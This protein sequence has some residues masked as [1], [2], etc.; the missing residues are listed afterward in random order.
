MKLRLMTGL[1]VLTLLGCAGD[2]ESQ[3]SQEDWNETAVE[4]ADE[5]RAKSD[6]TV[7][8]E[9]ATGGSGVDESVTTDEGVRWDTLE[10]PRGDEPTMPAPQYDPDAEEQGEDMPEE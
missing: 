7:Y 9:S 1:T 3:R 6:Q 4:K 10:E 5:S 8:D 2:S